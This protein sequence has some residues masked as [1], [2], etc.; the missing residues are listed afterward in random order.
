MAK[1]INEPSSVV[2]EMLAAAALTNPAIKLLDGYHVVVRAALDKAK[3]AI[4]SGG[5]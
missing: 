4:I 5:G 2:G 1:I 3:V